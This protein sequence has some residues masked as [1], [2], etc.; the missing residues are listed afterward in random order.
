[1][2][3]QTPSASFKSPSVPKSHE[4]RIENIPATVSSSQTS[5]SLS[6][7]DGIDLGPPIATLR[8]LKALTKYGDMLDSHIPTPERNGLCTFDPIQRGIMTV[9]DAQQAIDMYHTHPP[10]LY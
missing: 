9:K 3:R 5:V 1:M 2:E 10:A 6:G 7:M 4:D 8:S